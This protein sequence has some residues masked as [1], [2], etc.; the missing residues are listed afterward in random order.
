MDVQRSDRAYSATHGY[1]EYTA[2]GAAYS[3][4]RRATRGVVVVLRTISTP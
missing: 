4:K 3:I 1:G 2:E